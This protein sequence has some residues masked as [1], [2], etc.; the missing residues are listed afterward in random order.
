MIQSAQLPR[1]SVTAVVRVRNFGVLDSGS[2]Q[3]TQFL[4]VLLLDK[5][6]EISYDFSH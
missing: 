5:H 3:P 6:G 1:I 2:T 4:G